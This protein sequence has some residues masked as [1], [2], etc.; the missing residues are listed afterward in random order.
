MNTLHKDWIKS[1]HTDLHLQVNDMWDYISPARSPGRLEA[2]GFPAE[3]KLFKWINSDF[4]PALVNYNSVYAEWENPAT[5]P[6]MQT[7]LLTETEEA[8]IPLYRLLH[9]AFK[10]SQFVTNNDLEAMGM[11]RRPS[12]GANPPL[13]PPVTVPGLKIERPSQGVV[14]VH[15]QDTDSPGKAKP[16]GVHGIELLWGFLDH[17][18][19]SREELTRSA[20]DTRTPYRFEFGLEDVGKHL[21]IFARWENTR[22]E[23]GPW[24]EVYRT[25]VS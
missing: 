19:T 21:Y 11:P 15:F 17:E 8:F 13:P 3:S 18:P 24:S 12:G 5:R 7:K 25:I 9:D 22:G 20:F 6:A 23:K 1:N 4:V 14:L 16:R 2:F 10:G